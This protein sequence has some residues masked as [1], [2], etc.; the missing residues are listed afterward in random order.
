MAETKIYSRQIIDPENLA[1]GGEAPT[2][3]V[4]NSGKTWAYNDVSN[5]NLVITDTGP[6]NYASAPGTQVVMFDFLSNN[7]FTVSSSGSGRVG[8]FAIVGR[9]NTSLIS[10]QVWGQGL[11]LGYGEPAVYERAGPRWWPSSQVQTW[12]NSVGSGGYLHGETDGYPDRLLQES[13]TYRVILETTLDYDNRRYIRYRLLRFDSTYSQWQIERDTGDVFDAHPQPATLGTGLA[14][15]HVFEQTDSPWTFTVS[16]IRVFWRAPRPLLPHVPTLTASTALSG[17]MTWTGDASRLQADTS[18]SD[19]EDRWAF[20]DTSG[21]TTFL[22]IPAGS[23]NQATYMA[24]NSPSVTGNFKVSF[25]GMVGN[26]FDIESL[27]V[28]ETAGPIRIRTN[29]STRWE[30]GATGGSTHT[31]NLTNAGN[32]TFSGDGR[33]MVVSTTSGTFP[34]RWAMQDATGATTVLAIP[35]GSSNQA[36]YMAANSPSLTGTY[37]TAFM[38]MVGSNFDI[39]S[40]GVGEA[41]GAIRMRTGGTTRFQINSGGGATHT[42]NFTNTGTMAV[43]GGSAFGGTSTWNIAFTGTRWRT[44]GDGAPSPFDTDTFATNVSECADQI[45]GLMRFIAALYDDLK[46]RKII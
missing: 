17:V 43:G 28:G 31:G 12:H 27:G 41:A 20:R 30:I 36:T 34:N 1:G 32:L 37:K 13:T 39:E 2:T 46:A 18:N 29:G 22:V 45:V 26:N 21:A 19:F 23:S 38:G 11:I 40:L 24:A 7:Y 42:G 6:S 5:T 35:G 8:H 16:N 33:R 10:T 3:V 14:I 44:T 25:M 15:G 4:T 9:C